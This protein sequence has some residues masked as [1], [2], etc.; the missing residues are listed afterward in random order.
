M[1]SPLKPQS[2]ESLILTTYLSIFNPE[3]TQASLS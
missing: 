3:A 2:T 1:A